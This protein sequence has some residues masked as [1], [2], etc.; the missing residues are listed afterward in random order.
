MI[1][2]SKHVQSIPVFKPPSLCSLAVPLVPVLIPL[3][4]DLAMGNDPDNDLVV[5]RNNL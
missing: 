5:D 2:N 4:T 1:P 3:I